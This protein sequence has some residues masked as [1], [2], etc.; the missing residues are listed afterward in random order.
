MIELLVG[1]PYADHPY[2]HTALRVL[3]TNIEKIYDF[4]RY[5]RTWGVGNSEGDGVLNVWNS[6]DAYIAEENSLG[7]LTTGF[8]YDVPENRVV[9]IIDF[10]QAEIGS[11]NQSDPVEQKARMSSKITTHWGQTALPSACRPPKSRSRTLNVSGSDS[12]TA[13]D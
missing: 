8:A 10:Y 2:G 5:G 4:G 3:T 7:R 9:A 6:F 13:G 12:G 11:K 1:G